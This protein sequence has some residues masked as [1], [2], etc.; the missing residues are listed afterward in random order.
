MRQ[1]PNFAWAAGAAA[2]SRYGGWQS[3]YGSRSLLQL[4][5]EYVRR[6]PEKQT[7]IELA[8]YLVI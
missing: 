1:L 8:T 3:A 4:H 5:P 2:W 7:L 6:L